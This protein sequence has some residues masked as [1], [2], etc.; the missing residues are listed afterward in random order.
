MV[1]DRVPALSVVCGSGQGTCSVCCLCFWTGYLLSV[2]CGSG[3][4]TCFGEVLLVVAEVLEEGDALDGRVVAPRRLQ[5]HDLRVGV[6]ALSDSLPR[7][8]KLW[9]TGLLACVCS[10]RLGGSSGRY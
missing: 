3:Q 10:Q 8:S 7:D 4:G 5:Q 1:Q 6:L 2:V 9:S